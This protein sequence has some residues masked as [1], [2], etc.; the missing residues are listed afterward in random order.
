[1]HGDLE[2]HSW[3]EISQN[4]KSTTWKI[5]RANVRISID[6]QCYEYSAESEGNLH[7]LISLPQ[8]NLRLFFS[9]L[10][11]ALERIWIW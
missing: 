10:S 1:V 7:R 4:L 8:S 6:L 5:C 11:N 3:Y 2:R 9:A